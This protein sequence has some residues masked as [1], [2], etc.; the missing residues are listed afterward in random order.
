M[1]WTVYPEAD[2]YAALGLGGQQI[3]VYPSQNLIVVTTASLEAYAEAP[4][5]ENMLNEYI[6]PAIK[7][8]HPLTENPEAYSRL[9]TEIETAANPVQSAISLPETAL[10]ISGSTY[11]FE[12][13]LYGWETLEFTFDPESPTAQ[14][15][16]NGIPLQVGMDNIY[17]LSDNWPGGEILLRGRWLDENI[18]CL[19]YPYPMDSLTVLG[20]L[21]ETEFQLKFDGNQIEV[22]EKQLVF[23]GE[24]VI[25]KG[26]INE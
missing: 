13:N 3:H 12:E 1:G 10:E 26:D 21:G 22:T 4:E 5:I 14:I 24:P 19:D 8:T 17:R 11:T 20:E 9:R 7:S 23:G 25:F 16:F 2:H 18:F 15:V 6:L